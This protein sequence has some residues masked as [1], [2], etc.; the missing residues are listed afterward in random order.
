MLPYEIVTRR[1]QY[2]AAFI[3]MGGLEW[4]GEHQAVGLDALKAHR[5][6]ELA[7]ERSGGFAMPTIWYAEPRT[8]LLMEANADPDG[9]IAAKMGLPPTNFSIEHFGKS[10]DQQVEFFVQ[11]VFHVLVQ[12]NT[13]GMNAVL[14]LAGHYPLMDFAREAIRRFEQ[15]ERFR[16]TRAYCAIEPFYVGEGQWECPGGDHGAMW[17]T[18][19]LWYLRPDC[20]DLS[21]YKG[22]EHEE[23]IGVMDGPDP[24]TSASPELGRACVELIVDAMVRK[25]RELLD[26][27]L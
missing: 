14:L 11:T 21:V 2:P 9:K 12:M 23:L 25:S 24:R 18:S 27:V 26:C 1:R 13:L 6:C 3:G 5:L 4:H 22:R 16:S 17:E 15:I 8:H 20:V 19:Y 10:A 7:A